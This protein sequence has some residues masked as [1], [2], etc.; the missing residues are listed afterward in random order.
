M[1]GS[2]VFIRNYLKV[3]N[4]SVCEENNVDLPDVAIQSVFKP[5]G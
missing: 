2:G 4:V 5:H 1:D 3:R